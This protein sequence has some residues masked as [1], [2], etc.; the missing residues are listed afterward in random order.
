M[1]VIDWEMAQIGVTNLDLGQII[2]EL[3]QLKLFKDITA[4]LWIVQGFVEAYGAVSD[5]FAFR[6]A[7]QIGAHLITFG[8]SV[9][10]WGTPEQVETIAR[11]GRDIIVHAW[12]KD[13]DWFRTHDLACLFQSN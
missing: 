12:N 6:T 11:T 1:F 3:Y 10:G 8:T 13:R 7:I 5:D 4:G 9:E 2:A